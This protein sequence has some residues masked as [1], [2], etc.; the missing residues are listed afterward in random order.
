MGMSH[1]PHW[2]GLSSI[3]QEYSCIKSITLRAGKVLMEVPT[4]LPSFLLWFILL[5][6][7]LLFFVIF[8]SSYFL[9]ILMNVPTFSDTDLSRCFFVLIFFVFCFFKAICFVFFLAGFNGCANLFWHRSVLLLIFPQNSFRSADR[10]NYSRLMLQF[11]K[12]NLQKNIQI[13][14]K[15]LYETKSIVWTFFQS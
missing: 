4:F 1:F 2:E 13:Y 14:A 12:G 3:H 8:S 7:Y 9:L 10:G 5:I 6:C 15:E 11:K